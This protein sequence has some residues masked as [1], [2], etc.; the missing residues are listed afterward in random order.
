MRLKL[1]VTTQALVGVALRQYK[2]GLEAGF[3][4]RVFKSATMEMTA[5]DRLLAQVEIDSE[6]EEDDVQG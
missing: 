5:I 2:E 1:D 3:E 6:I 4:P